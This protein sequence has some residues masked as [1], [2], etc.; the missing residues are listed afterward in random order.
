[1]AIFSSTPPSFVRRETLQIATLGGS[2]KHVTSCSMHPAAFGVCPQEATLV[3]I[4]GFLTLAG[5]N[6]RKHGQII[7]GRKER[8]K[9]GGRE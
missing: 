8:M 6:K 2:G 7:R 9:G 5:S 3:A 1:L 4:P